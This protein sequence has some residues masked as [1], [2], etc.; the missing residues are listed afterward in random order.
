MATV[1]MEVKGTLMRTK[2]D[3]LEKVIGV[4]HETVDGPAH[5][6][7]IMCDMKKRVMIYLNSM[8][9]RSQDQRQK[10]QKLA[11]VFEVPR[12]PGPPPQIPTG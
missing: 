11:V 12:C 6:T 5:W 4:L 7:T 1:F 9:D 10:A 3:T 2:L 8:R